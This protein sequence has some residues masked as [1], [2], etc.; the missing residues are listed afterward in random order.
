MYQVRRKSAFVLE[1]CF[2]LFCFFGFAVLARPGFSADLGNDED[3]GKEENTDMEA[4]KRWLRDKR[5]I[6]LKES[7]GNLSLSGEVRV[8]MQA[9]EETKNKIRQ[10]GRGG[11]TEVP[12]T[13]FDCEVNIMLDYRSGRTWGAVKLEYDNA[14][15][16]VNG[17]TNRIALERAYLGGRI[18][19][20]DTF[21][22]D[23]ELGR[24][25]LGDVFDSKIEFNSLFDGILVKFSK[26]SRAVGSFYCNLG[27]FLVNENFY[28]FGYVLELGLLNIGS[29]GLYTKFSLVDWKKK[30]SEPRQSDSFKFLVSQMIFG[31]QKVVSKYRKL[32]KVYLA[33]LW[34]PL[35]RPN[36]LT[37]KSY[38]NL[39]GYLGVSLG[40]VVKRGDWALDLN[41]QVLGAQTVPDFD[42]GGI[43]RGNSAGIGFY[44]TGNYGLGDQTTNSTC[45][46]NGN[47]K[48]L[49]FEALY[50]VTSNLTVLNDL[51][52][53]S[54]LKKK[55]GPKMYFFQY[56]IEFIYA[57]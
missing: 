17:T 43:G 46:G 7:G 29:S 41:Y 54:N 47:Y 21:T 53:S 14:M 31:Y 28:H 5:L 8:E 19:D 30:Y 57:F 12:L 22:F 24:R 45:V 50:A 4:L 27:A 51:E 18:V 33:G 35:A 52:F 16:Q 44:S 15:G 49:I 32:L 9:A 37:H 38:A 36:D 20:G 2:F 40:E 26:A 23:L 42:V 56:K 25:Y 13:A 55:I 34:N 11:A 10:R 39:G 48:G 3:R 1:F 6:T